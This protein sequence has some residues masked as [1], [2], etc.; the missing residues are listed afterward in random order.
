MLG[1]GS[2]PS[3]FSD[4]G[5]S[6]VAPN[7]TA[8]TPTP[9]P[10]VKPKFLGAAWKLAAL[11]AKPEP[12]QPVIPAEVAEALRQAAATTGASG[13]RGGA[14]STLTV[15]RPSVIQRMASALAGLAPNLATSTKA[16]DENDDEDD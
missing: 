13:G 8:T 12:Q 9:A 11:E 5:T 1:N 2:I 14:R 3:P 15:R 7:S 16:E 6:S 10:A 4:G